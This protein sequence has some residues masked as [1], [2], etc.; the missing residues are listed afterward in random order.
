[1]L[2]VKIL[3]EIV[4]Q[5]HFLGSC[6]CFLVVVYFQS[7]AVGKRDRPKL[8][9]L[10]NPGPGAG[11]SC[12]ELYSLINIES[13]FE[14]LLRD[15]RYNSNWQLRTATATCLKSLAYERTTLSDTPTGMEVYAELE[16]AGAEI[17][18]SRR[19]YEKEG[20]V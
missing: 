16:V 2:K 11:A 17:D 5:K 4:T 6:W 8:Q 18:V 3:I 20:D 19:E 15:H 1:M 12:L 14:R 7:L 13:H 9:W 10:E